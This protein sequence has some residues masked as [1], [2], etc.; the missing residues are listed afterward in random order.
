MSFNAM[1]SILSDNAVAL[2]GGGLI[3]KYKFL[4]FLKIPHTLA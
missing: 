4:G 2:K 1:Y 3:E